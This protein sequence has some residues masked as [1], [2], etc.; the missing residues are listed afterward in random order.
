VE[1]KPPSNIST[2]F[3][4]AMVFN[5][6]HSSSYDSLKRAPPCQTQRSIGPGRIRKTISKLVENGSFFFEFKFCASL[7]ENQLLFRYQMK[8]IVLSALAAMVLAGSTIRD[9]GCAINS[10]SEVR[11]KRGDKEERSNDDDGKDCDEG[12]TKGKKAWGLRRQPTEE[13]KARWRANRPNGA[14]GPHRQFTEEE[15]AEWRAAHPNGARHVPKTEE[16]KAKWRAEHLNARK[17]YVKHHKFTEEEKS[18][19]RSEHPNA[20]K[21]AD[22]A[23]GCQAPTDPASQ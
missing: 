18:K 17:G 4:C 1:E 16:E 21:H 10:V 6:K 23:E 12:D 22:K 7:A 9:Q 19:W 2:S 15:K 11:G 5:P 13:E 8:F 20:S 14:K 3:A